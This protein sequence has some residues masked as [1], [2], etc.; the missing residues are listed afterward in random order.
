MFIY[1][2][3]ALSKDNT[4]I[5]DTIISKSKNTAFI[6]LLESEQIPIKINFKS[7]FYLDK[8][9][10]DYRIHFF[11]Q[12]STLSSSGI[13]ILQS[14]Y[15]LQDNNH[16]PLWKMIIKLAINDLKKG[17]SLASSLKK[18][19]SIFS[20]TIVS[21]VEV[22]EKMGQYEN[23]FKII[24]NML[25]YHEQT[26]KKIRQSLRYPTVLAL[27]SV[28]LIFIMLVYVLPQFETIYQSFGH[29]LPFMTNLIIHLSKLLSEYSIYPLLV[30]ITLSISA[31]KYKK[32]FITC[33]I[34]IINF[35]PM[36]RRLSREHNLNLYF[37]MLSS[38]LQAGL[39]LIES[40]KCAANTVHHPYYKRACLVVHQSVVKG[41]S[42]SAAMKNQPFFPKMACQIIS[43]A[44]ESGQLIHFAQ[45]LFTHF[46]ESFI[47]Q[48]ETL[49]KRIEPILLIAMALLVGGIMIAMYLPIFNLG[50]V[51][52]GI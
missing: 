2:Y 10:I 19:P 20:P 31:F 9:N 41:Q 13:N 40:L 22:A 26:K 6:E 47:T 16:P 33:S 23:N 30:I 36:F 15:I 37:S 50:N 27:L 29:N 3:T 8:K 5:K 35:I 44:E 49:L 39:P 45:Y 38:T 1:S 42:L 11:Y 52:T 7:I 28:S 21:L 17:D 43:V 18:T 51:I 34:K 48:T 46:S 24:A 4:I 12:L 25:K 14:L 32:H